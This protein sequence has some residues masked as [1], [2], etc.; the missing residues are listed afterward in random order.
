[1][2][3]RPESNAGP[4]QRGVAVP[5]HELIRCIGRGSYGEVWLARNVMGYYR[6]V[7]I[8]YRS[9]FEHERPFEREYDG[10]RR[11]EP[12]S[13]THPSQLAVLHVGRSPANHYF[14]YVME[15]ADNAAEP[16]DASVA[17]DPAL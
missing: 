2:L 8:V 9:T 3:S 10:I 15:L 6:A 4:E 17:S 5:D 13:R 16:A 1:M 12:V 7:K 11:F 14:Y